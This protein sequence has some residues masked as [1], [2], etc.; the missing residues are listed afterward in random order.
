MGCVKTLII[1]P[2]AALHLLV[3]AGRN[4]ADDLMPYPL[5]FQTLLEEGWLVPVGSKAIGKFRSII[6]SEA[7]DGE[8]EGF[9]KVFHKLGGRIGVMFFKGFHEVP[10]GKIINGRVLEKLLTYNLTV[11]EACERDEF[12][13]RL[14]SLTG[15]GQLLIRLWYVF[16]IG[17]MYSHDA[18]FYEETVEAGDGARISTLRGL[19]P[20][21]DKSGI[22]VT[23]SHIQDK[24]LFLWSMLVGVMVRAS[25]VFAQGFNG[26]SNRRLQR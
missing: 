11:F 10:P 3:V 17:R 1:L 12:H 18:L 25:K 14:D 15:I 5:C 21:D 26:G 9:N 4:G 19:D 2:V 8:G 23:A 16:W 7:L 24:F 13:V 6:R 22:R 20:E